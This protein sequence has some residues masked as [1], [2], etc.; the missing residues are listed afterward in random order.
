[1]NIHLGLVVM[2]DLYFSLLE[3]RDCVLL[4]EE[5]DLYFSLLEGSDSVSLR[6]EMTTV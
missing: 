2:K 6:E 1:M 5:K 3:G 4:I